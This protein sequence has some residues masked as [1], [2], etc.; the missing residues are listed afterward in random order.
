LNLSAGIDDLV[1]AWRRRQVALYFAWTETVARYRRSVLGP[2]WL[3][4]S[5]AIGVLGLG[6]VWSTLFQADRSEFIPSLTAGLVLWQ[7]ISGALSEASSVFPRNAGAILNVRLPSFL[8]SL[9]MLLRQ[10]INLGH[11]LVVVL[12]VF[13]IYPQHLSPTALLAIPGVA[14]VALSLLGLIQLIGFLGARYRDLDPLISSFMP[15]LFFLSPVI[16][17]ARQLGDAYLVMQFNPVAHWIHIVRDPLLGQVPSL[18]SYAITL[19]IGLLAWLGALWV[20]SSRGHRLP[21][22]V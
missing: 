13:L 6:Y 22:W 2:F 21:Y 18:D 14:L 12:A 10:L 4:G 8:L 16:Y 15:I 20:T 3:V 5:T 19:A 7:F 9:Q 11:N 17:Q 1:R